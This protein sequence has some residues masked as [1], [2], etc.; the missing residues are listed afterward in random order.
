VK[1]KNLFAL[2]VGNP[3]GIFRAFGVAK[4]FEAF[5]SDYKGLEGCGEK[6]EEN[7]GDKQ[8]ATE[9]K[10]RDTRR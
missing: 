6:E 10:T 9:Y 2:H 8:V 5:A 7:Q 1:R 4:N 3:T